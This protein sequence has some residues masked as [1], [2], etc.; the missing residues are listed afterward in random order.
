M[1]KV[2]FSRLIKL[3]ILLDPEE[4]G[5]AIMLVGKKHTIVGWLLSQLCQL[6]VRSLLDG[7][8]FLVL[9]VELVEQWLF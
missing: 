3:H 4:L 5:R 9:F 2:S 7:K 1:R 8:L 6:E